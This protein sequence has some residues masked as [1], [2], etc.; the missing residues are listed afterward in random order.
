LIAITSIRNTEIAG[1]RERSRLQKQKLLRKG[2]WPI[3]KC[4]ALSTKIFCI[5]DVLAGFFT[6]NT[7]P[8]ITREGLQKAGCLEEE[9][10]VCF[11]SLVPCFSSSA[12]PRPP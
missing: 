5:T 1:I 11:I 7:L 6:D 4:F 8:K 12:A 9:A 10:K 3:L 2:K